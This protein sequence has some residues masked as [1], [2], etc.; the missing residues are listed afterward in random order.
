MRALMLELCL[1]AAGAVSTTAFA[2]KDLSDAE[3]NRLLRMADN[4]LLVKCSVA[5]EFDG[6]LD[7]YGLD[8]DIEDAAGPA[9]EDDQAILARKTAQ[10]RAFLNSGRLTPRS[11]RPKNAV[12][13]TREFT[14]DCQVIA[15]A[16]VEAQ[17]LRLRVF[18]DN[19]P[20][21]GKNLKGE[22]EL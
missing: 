9:L 2:A 12:V 18:Y 21:K 10:V 13:I 22:E 7:S 8:M 16:A 11:P 5:Y 20:K 4:A 6:F 15:Q 17:A 14:H 19:S 3:V 1:V